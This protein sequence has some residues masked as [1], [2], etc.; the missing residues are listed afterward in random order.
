MAL[1]LLMAIG[2]AEGATQRIITSWLMEANR[3]YTRRAQIAALKHFASFAR[4]ALLVKRGFL[5]S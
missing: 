1:S 5:S 3:G 4:P 2:R